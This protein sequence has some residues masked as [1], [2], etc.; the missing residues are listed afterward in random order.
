MSYTRPHHIVLQLLL[1]ILVTSVADS[2]QDDSNTKFKAAVYEHAVVLPEVKANMSREE[3]LV[4]M[5]KNL[6]VYREQ[7]R[8]AA[9]S[10]A[11]IVVFP[12]DG[13]YGFQF[14]TRDSI[15]PYLE[16]IPDPNYVTWSPCADPGVWVGWKNR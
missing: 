3:A 7:T 6:D 15:F 9:L 5:D 12:E 4:A 16:Q 10:G 11:S 13:L 8:L 1:L 2:Q 14:S